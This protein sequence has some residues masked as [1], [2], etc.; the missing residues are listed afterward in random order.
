M[1]LSDQLVL[2]IC[3]RSPGAPACCFCVSLLGATNGHKNMV[4]LCRALLCEDCELVKSLS[5]TQV[6]TRIASQEK[7]SRSK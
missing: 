1:R 6:Q 2:Q 4:A 3:Q 5:C 7:E